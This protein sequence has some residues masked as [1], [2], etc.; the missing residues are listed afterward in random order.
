MSSPRHLNTDDSPV[1]REPSEDPEAPEAA[2]RSEEVRD[3][4]EPESPLQL[5]KRSWFY[6][7]RKTVREFA[8]DECTDLAAALTYYAVLALFPAAIAL[9]SLVSLVGQ[10]RSSVDTILQILRNVG[11]PGVAHT[12]ESTLVELSSSS[13]GGMALLLGLAGAVW[14]ASGYVGAFGRA[15]NRMYEVPEGRPI[16]KL[17]P[18]NLVLT[19][20]LIVLA[21]AALVMLVISGPVARAIG[22]QIGLGS[23]TVMI[24]NI[25][26]WPVLVL[27]V[28]L[29]VAILYWGT[30]NVRQPRFR[31]MSVG[32]GVAILVWMAASAAFGLYVATFSSYDRTYG[33]LT[34]V[35]VFLLWLWLTNIALLFGAE[36]DAEIE[37]G[38]ELQ[39]GIAAEESIQLPPRDSRNIRKAEKKREKDVARGR[40]IRLHHRRRDEDES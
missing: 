6:V 1:T 21:A 31:W 28:V 12:L 4:D 18:A 7:A 35:I 39:S 38:R 30:P 20:V 24:W 22:D 16:W 10:G 13:A 33:S 2:D 23:T 27:V 37:R 3:T 8:H 17:R 11:A 19:L 15:M 40:A 34:G 29:I 9:I 36:L 5:T 14:S 25:A 32:A 26:K